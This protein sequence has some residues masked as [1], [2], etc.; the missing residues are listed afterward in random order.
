VK[1]SDA[2]VLAVVAVVGLIAAF[3]FV[4]L[5]PKR[6]QE[7]DL[8]SQV[9]DLQSQ[10]SQQ[11]QTVSTAQQARSTFAASYHKLVV[12]GKA[13]PGDSEQASLLV[14]LSGLASRAG[15]EFSGLSLSQDAGAATAAPPP[16]PT[17]ST[18]TDTSSTTTTSSSTTDTSTTAASATPSAAAAVIPTEASAASL[19]LGATVGPAGLPVMPYDL[20]FKGGYFQIAKFL[21]EVDSLVHTG[22]DDVTVSGRLITVNSFDLSPPSAGTGTTTATAP[23]SLQ[24][25]LSVTTYLA[26]ADQGLTGGATPIGPAPTTPST[27]IPAA[28]TAPATAP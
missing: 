15:V 23:G 7:S 14:Q 19:P 26:P 16:A 20:T 8:S 28:T 17:T 21:H 24:A 25:T 18:T 3:W 5:A 9:S 22:A 6:S 1:R 12:L 4:V 2:T 10:L 27:A 11:Q 13:V